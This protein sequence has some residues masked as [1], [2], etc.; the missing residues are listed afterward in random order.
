MDSSSPLLEVYDLHVSFIANKGGALSA[1]RG[2]TFEIRAGE[3]IGLVGESGSGKTVTALALMG[4]LNPLQC[5]VTGEIRFNNQDFACL[6]PRARRLIRGKQIAFISQNAMAA[7]NPTMKIGQ[8][9]GEVLGGGERKRE[10]MTWLDRVGIPDPSLRYYQFPHQLSGGMCQRVLIAMALASKP[11]LLIADEPTTALDPWLQQQI[12]ELLKR[13]QLETNMAL[14]FITHD[15]GLIARHSTST[16][17][18]YSGAIIE[19]GP[20]QELLKNPEHP[21]TRGLLASVPF[22]DRDTLLAPIPGMAPDLQRLPKG[23]AFAPR[24]TQA[25]R[26]CHQYRPPLDSVSPGHFAACWLQDL[27]AKGRL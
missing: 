11:R 10:V 4:L 25:L 12:L 1:V 15:I 24:C 14:L 20:T 21:Y 17:V 2:V 19:K 27:R 23:C 7:L 16:F 3:I 9:I 26:V 5:R 13:H 18:M 6:K 22:L 8:Q